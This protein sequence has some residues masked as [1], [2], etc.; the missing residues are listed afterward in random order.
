MKLLKFGRFFLSGLFLLT[1]LSLG[2]CQSASDQQSDEAPSQ[3]SMK[4]TPQEGGDAG[5]QPSSDT[6]PQQ[7]EQG[8]APTSEPQSE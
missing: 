4:S 5:A 3:Q 6:M 7:S 8:S 1:M 2:A